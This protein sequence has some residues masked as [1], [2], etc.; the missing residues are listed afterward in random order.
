MTVDILVLG[1]TG[2]TGKL[3]V[4]YLA[5]HPQRSTFSF[6]IAGRSEQKLKALVKELSL[7]ACLP[8]SSSRTL[9]LTV[10]VNVPKFVVDASQEGQVQKALRQTKVVINI[11]SPYLL[12]G[13]NIVRYVVKA[14]APC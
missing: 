5:N 3:V 10:T 14:H 13:E 9:L 11:M 12:L 6:G 4:R 8:F 7:G 2:L 1:A